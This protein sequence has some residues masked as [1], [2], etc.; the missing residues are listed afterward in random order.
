M[1][2]GAKR[3]YINTLPFL[4]FYIDRATIINIVAPWFL[5]YQLVLFDGRVE[6]LIVRL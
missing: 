5:C 2:L 6:Q 4:S 3:R 1:Y